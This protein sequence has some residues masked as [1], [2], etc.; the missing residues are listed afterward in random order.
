MG[1]V[2]TWL[3]YTPVMLFIVVLSFLCEQLDGGSLPPMSVPLL[4]GL[5]SGSSLPE[6]D[7]VALT[8]STEYSPS[9]ESI[10]WLVDGE[11]VWEDTNLLTESGQ[12][13][14][15]MM[16]VPQMGQTV[17][18]CKVIGRQVRSTFVTFSVQNKPK[19]VTLQSGDA[20]KI[21]ESLWVPFDIQNWKTS[22]LASSAEESDITYSRD[23][24]DFMLSK[25][26]DD[27]L[28]FDTTSLQEHHH[29]KRHKFVEELQPISLPLVSYSSSSSVKISSA[30]LSVMSL[31]LLLSSFS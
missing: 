17:I 18:E 3:P 13:M 11:H 7:P 14:S 1:V 24:Y 25:H 10:E 15:N 16:F 19:T 5:R 30:P 22:P 20:T 8:C 6:L 26:S 4:V 31:I 2:G 28:S 27:G 21:K 9:T 23:I 29:K 12:A